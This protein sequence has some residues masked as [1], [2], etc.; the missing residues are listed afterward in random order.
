MS[1]IL[2][3]MYQ[4]V[5]V[6]VKVFQ[7]HNV[8]PNINT[9]QSTET[10]ECNVDTKLYLTDYFHCASGVKQGC[11][12]SPFLFSMFISEFVKEI[13]SCGCQGVEL[14]TND[15]VANCLLYADDL[16]IFSDN[17]KD[18]QRKINA[19]HLFCQK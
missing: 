8:Q 6:S 17:V 2:K 19:L 10:C 7:Q 18:M 14:L 5:L 4:N 13:D 11:V 16:S 9:E 3:A 15:C 1:V 12:L